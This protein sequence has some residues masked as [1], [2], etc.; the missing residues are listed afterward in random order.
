MRSVPEWVGESDDHRPSARVRAR[1]FDKQ[2]GHCAKCDRYVGGERWHCDHAIP[3]WLKP[4]GN[5]ETNLQILCWD[6]H[7]VKTRREARERGKSNR[8]RMRHIGIRKPRR[9]RAWRKFDG[10]KVFATRE[11]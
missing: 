11:R 8:L 9:I 2:N 10:T 6:C 3:L 5:R 7:G 1:V 4:G